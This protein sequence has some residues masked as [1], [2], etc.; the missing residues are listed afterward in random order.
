MSEDNLGRRRSFPRTE[1]ELDRVNDDDLEIEGSA[2]A[3]ET[4][5][6]R[7]VSVDEFGRFVERFLLL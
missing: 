2:W 6:V 3:E 4:R 5:R 1:W 7:L